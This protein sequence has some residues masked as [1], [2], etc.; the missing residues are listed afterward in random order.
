MSRAWNQQSPNAHFANSPK[1][2]ERSNKIKTAIDYDYNNTQKLT[3][4][5][6]EM[7][8]PV[9]EHLYQQGLKNQK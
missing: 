7:Q 5:A 4:L 9:W 3:K 2:E 8:E 1:R 6:R